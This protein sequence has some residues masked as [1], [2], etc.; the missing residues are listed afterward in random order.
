MDK[1]TTGRQIAGGRAL[2]GLAQRDLARKAKISVPTL[3][4]MEASCGEAVGLINNVAAVRAALESAGVE[5]I[6]ENGGGA[7]VRLKKRAN[8]VEEISQ[9]INA[10]EDK[11]SSMPAP[12]E[13]SP[14]AGMNMM[15]KAV[16]KNDL[17][18]LKTRRK[19]INSNRSK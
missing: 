1:K 13:P 9:Q 18:K 19:R 10:L 11:I 8:G 4:R 2:V 5:F 6:A 17:A 14:E 15:R 3:K 12:T 7:G 16:A